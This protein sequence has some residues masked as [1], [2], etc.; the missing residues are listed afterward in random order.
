MYDNAYRDGNV[1]CGAHVV[2]PC[3]LIRGVFKPVLE[4]ATKER[5]LQVQVLSMCDLGGALYIAFKTATICG[6]LQANI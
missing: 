2:I 6:Q 3:G 5:D 1:A 4:S